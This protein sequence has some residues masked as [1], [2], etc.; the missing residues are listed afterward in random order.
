MLREAKSGETLE[1]PPLISEQAGTASWEFS[2]GTE[3]GCFCTFE[4]LTDGAHPLP[5][6]VLNSCRNDRC[7]SLEQRRTDKQDSKLVQFFAT[8]GLKASE[9][10]VPGSSAS[11]PPE[12]VK[13]KNSTGH[14]D[15]EEVRHKVRSLVQ[16][17]AV[18]YSERRGSFCFFVPHTKQKKL[19]RRIIALCH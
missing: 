11:Q 8:P 4:D 12:E 13:E 5:P 9:S 17:C 18:R 3:L 6:H 15:V 7:P 16:I 10:S 2:D 14:Q 19:G 1:I